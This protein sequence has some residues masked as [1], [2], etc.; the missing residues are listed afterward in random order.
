MSIVRQSWET[1]DNQDGDPGGGKT[2]G[3]RGVTSAVTSLSRYVAWLHGSGLE[4]LS[5]DEQIAAFARINAKEDAL[6]RR[7]SQRK[8]TETLPDSAG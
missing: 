8:E 4:T 6:S 3:R 2:L 5:P 1:D 7:R